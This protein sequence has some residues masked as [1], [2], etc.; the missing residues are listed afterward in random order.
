MRPHNT[1]AWRWLVRGGLIL[2]CLILLTDHALAFRSGPRR[3]FSPGP[4]VYSDRRFGGYRPLCRPYYYSRPYFLYSD[5]SDYYDYYYV[6]Y[7]PYQPYMPGAYQAFPEFRLPGFFQY[8]GA[9][10]K[11]ED[12]AQT[13][14]GDA[15]PDAAGGAE[16]ETAPPES[17]GR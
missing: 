2:G 8:P 7:P 5:Y 16:R 12:A 13:F 10:G 15:P 9:V 17:P 4:H 3:S 14:Q 1:P 11:G 6:P